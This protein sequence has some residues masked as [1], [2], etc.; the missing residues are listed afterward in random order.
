MLGESSDVPTYFALKVHAAS[1]HTKLFNKFA[2]NIFDICVELNVSF[3]HFTERAISF[4]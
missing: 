3:D 2:F 1:T 4:G